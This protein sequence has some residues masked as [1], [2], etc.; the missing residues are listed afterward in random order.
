LIF[1]SPQLALF[2]I[3]EG[4]FETTAD[5]EIARGERSYGHSSW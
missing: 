4:G 3:I 5:V 2:I 1:F